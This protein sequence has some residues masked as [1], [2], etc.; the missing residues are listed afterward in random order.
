MSSPGRKLRGAQERQAL[1]VAR[2][3]GCCCTPKITWQPGQ[4][5]RLG[6]DLD[7]PRL[8]ELRAQVGESPL[9]FDLL[10]HRLWPTSGGQG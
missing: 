8:A 5:I 9:P 6:H 10:T 1:A 7:C 3:H 2:A 4:L